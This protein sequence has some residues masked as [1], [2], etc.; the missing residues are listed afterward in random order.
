MTGVEISVILPV[1]N[2]E[3]NVTLVYQELR[4][5]LEALG[6]SYEIIFVDDG[7]SDGSYRVL[8]ALA[9]DD[10]A[11]AVIRLRRNYGQTAALSAGIERCAGSIVILMDADL[12]NDPRDIGRLL[13]KLDE[14][15]DVVSGWRK[16][17]KDKWLTRTLPSRVANGLISRVTGVRLHD[18][19]CT[20]KA[21]RRDVLVHVRLYGEMH[22]FIPVYAT[23]AGARVTEI[24]VNHRARKYGK[25]K[26]GLRRIMRVPLDLV[27]VKFL[28][29]YSTKPLYLFG[30]VGLFLLLGAIGA[31]AVAVAQRFLP[32]FV[33][34]HNNPLLLLGAVLAVLAI[35][36]VMMG[37]LAELIMRTYYESQGKPTYTIRSIALRGQGQAIREV[38]LSGPHNGVVNGERQTPSGTRYSAPP[39]LVELGAVGGEG[40][41]VPVL[42]T[43]PS[44]GRADAAGEVDHGPVSKRDV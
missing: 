26:Y 18:Y 23:W 1:F 7:S 41:M 21:Y 9:V 13:A 43:V 11:V 4:A 8:C 37:L 40:T 42:P 24:P 34:L 3:K 35:Q 14:G 33:R 20:L 5:A 19:G 31:E 39:T 17:R 28:G 38:E 44:F 2:E 16:Q 29:T 10:P 36:I 32:P 30:L 12:Q 27:T 6:R 25:S 15:Y 22:R